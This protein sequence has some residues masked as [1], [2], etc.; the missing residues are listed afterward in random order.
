MLAK[1]L[2][3]H[4]HLTDE[5]F[6]D[7]LEQIM[8]MLRSLNMKAV[9]VSMDLATARK[10][11]ALTNSYDD[12]VI[13]FMG[14][15]P[16]SAGESLDDFSD[17]VADNSS[18]IA[19]VGEIGLDRKYVDNDD[20]YKR[21][22]QVFESMLSFA[23]KLGKPTSI[24]SRGSLDDVLHTLQ[25]YKLKGVLLHWFAGSKKQLRQATD[26]GYYVSYGPALV[27]SEDKRSLL[28]DTPTE[29]VLVETDGPVRYT[30]CFESKAALPS[31][32]PSVVF[33]LA[34]TLRLN[35]DDA[36]SMLMQ[37]SAKYLNNAL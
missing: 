12:V 27:Y 26:S 25:S 29:F 1:L 34:K 17:F 8:G 35:Y 30:R 3:A 6:S 10:N 32:L 22:K 5:E 23:E 20:G 18:K 9:S 11:L 19:G 7:L 14:I 28:S 33:A 31:F 24:H 15:H 4:V 37:N 16:W 13:P 21:Q 2:D 36:C